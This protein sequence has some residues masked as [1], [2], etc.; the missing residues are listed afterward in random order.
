MDVPPIPDDEKL[1][2]E[3]L[4]RYGILDT[5]TEEMLDDLT[6]LA[7]AICSTPISLVSLIGK[8]RQWFKS[9]INLPL[10]ET[11]MEVS[12]CSHAILESGVFSVRAEF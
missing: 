11:S 7:S 1:R 2:L 8:K 3:S 6:Q 4:Y 12:F 9:N 5:E 10:K